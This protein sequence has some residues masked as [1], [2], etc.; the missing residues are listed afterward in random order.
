MVFHS[1]R[2][3]LFGVVLIWSVML[4][5]GEIDVCLADVCKTSEGQDGHQI[6]FINNSK[7]GVT[8]G[9]WGAIFDSNDNP[10]L[11]FKGY[12]HPANWVID[13]KEGSTLNWCAPKHFNGRF[14]A[15][16]G[17]VGG[18]CKTGDCCD[19]S[20]SSSCAGNVCNK[21][22]EPTTLAE[23][24]FDSKS[25]NY[26]D[27]SLVDGYDFPLLMQ[28]S[29][30]TE[31]QSKETTCIQAGCENLPQCPWKLLVNGVCLG[32]YKK[33]EL[34]Y[35]DFRYQKDYYPLAVACAP[36]KFIKEGETPYCGCGK[37]TDCHLEACPT[38]FVVANPYTDP[39]TKVT[40]LSSG[41]SPLQTYTK[42]PEKSQVTCD[43]TKPDSADCHP[44]AAYYKNYVTTITNQCAGTGQTIS[45][46]YS[47]QY[48]DKNGLLQCSEN[49]NLGF[50]I[51]IPPRSNQSAKNADM[52]TF[53]PGDTAGQVPAVTGTIT[54]QGG[55]VRKLLGP[56]MLKIAVQNG[57]KLTL[58]LN[59]SEPGF[60]LTCQVSYSVGNG[61]SIEDG[62]ADACKDEKLFPWGK[63]EIP[64]SFPNIQ[65]CSSKTEFSL[66][67]SPA[68]DVKGGHVCIGADT[69]PKS[70]TSDKTPPPPITVLLTDSTLFRLYQDCGRAKLLQCSADF[71]IANG[72]TLRVIDG[73]SDFCNRIDW[74]NAFQTK[75][76]GLAN[77]VADVDCVAGT[78]IKE[79]PATYTLQD[80]Q[81][82]LQLHNGLPTSHSDPKK[83]DY[84]RDGDIDF[85]DT[86]MMLRNSIGL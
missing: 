56:D 80:A 28:P 3:G 81:S 5:N 74:G 72:F 2:L 49:T 86:I 75:N 77:P 46:V 1:Q 47:W 31:D 12:A 70:F 44:W 23:L 40:L 48:D 67:I 52:I 51:T 17:C 54:D 6:T 13:E 66:Q 76:L 33:F 79:C 82:G 71:S 35:Y 50:V 7:E 43:P 14:F 9:V 78:Y 36:N 10:I 26:F 59:C 24:F 39:P 57:D 15:R 58:Q 83:L 53:K 20:L 34:D 19:E 63:T 8:I 84:D 37:S 41:C 69:T 18:K 60:S 68:T 21:A 29:N 85:N 32:P 27:I 62:S 65:S 38:Q 30:T 16:T 42:E 11:P 4:F 25:G 73:Q 61:F 64:L 45:K 22:P 55:K